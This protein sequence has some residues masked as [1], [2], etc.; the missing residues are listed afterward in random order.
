M[1]ECQV[2]DKKADNFHMIDFMYG[3][4]YVFVN[5]ILPR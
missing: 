2:H 1:A 3:L 4:W 5:V